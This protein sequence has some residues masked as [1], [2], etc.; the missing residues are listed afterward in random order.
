MGK[1]FVNLSLLLVSVVVSLAAAEIMLRS[2]SD[3]ELSGTWQIFD[4]RG[5]RLNKSAGSLPHHRSGYSA[6][7]SFRHPHL[8]SGRA[9]EGQYRI[10]VLGESFTFGWLLDWPDTYV[11]HLEAQIGTEFGPS[12]FEIA[13]A[14]V[15]GWGVD[16]YLAYLEEYGDEVDPD[17]VTIFLNTDDIERAI[18]T[19]LYHVNQGELTASQVAIP[20]HK[21]VI[22][23]L[24]IYN[25]LLS[26]SYL[27]DAMRA[28]YVTLRY[29]GNDGPL[30]W[31]PGVDD[32]EVTVS[33]EKDIMALE[34]A[35][36][37]FERIIE[38]CE[39][40]GVTLLVVTTAWHN[41]PYEGKSANE[42]F[43]AE[44]PRFFDA[45]EVKYFDGSPLLVDRKYDLRS[46]IFIKDDGHPNEEGARL[47]AEIN[48]PF[49]KAEL[50]EFCNV[51]PC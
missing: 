24:P 29:G 41:P 8:R 30:F 26:R 22:K 27:L 4:D 21:K 36:H 32:T 46:P 28:S 44:A 1:W 17:I 2:I 42:L 14:A 10:L 13:N 20:F 33:T 16:S 5:L 47:I 51:K 9:S 34:L 50:A 49:L 6:T 18:R 40:R 37:I 19:G 15:G 35:Q 48:W 25:Y 38:W 7:Y 23:A 43:M 12:L 45:R 39:E 31:G 11:G 3:H